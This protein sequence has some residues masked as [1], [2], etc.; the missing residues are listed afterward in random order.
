MKQQIAD[1]LLSL[2]RKEEDKL[3]EQPRRISTQLGVRPDFLDE[4]EAPTRKIESDE[5]DEGGQ[6]EDV[7]AATTNED[8]TSLPG[9]LPSFVRVLKMISQIFFCHFA[10]FFYHSSFLFLHSTGLLLD[11]SNDLMIQKLRI[12][13]MKK[14]RKE[15]RK[16]EKLEKFR[17]HKAISKDSPMLNEEELLE[18]LATKS[19]DSSVTTL[20]YSEKQPSFSEKQPSS[21]KTTTTTRPISNY[22]GIEGKSASGSDNNKQSTKD[23]N[24]INKKRKPSVASVREFAAG[25]GGGGITAAKKNAASATNTEDLNKH[26]TSKSGG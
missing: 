24:K 25:G 9:K 6:Q 8:L 13:Q 10:H 5:P 3:C 12:E 23:L 17:L 2:M 21:S 26:L 18:K 16:L 22:R 11:D 7:T 15:I 4:D 19:V 1:K 14:L 20:S